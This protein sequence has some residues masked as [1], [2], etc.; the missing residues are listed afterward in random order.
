ME[1]RE[2]Q[3]QAGEEGGDSGEGEAFFF[4]N[5]LSRTLTSV[6]PS[7]GGGKKARGYF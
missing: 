6:S 3:P 7:L 2:G 4:L 5:F 1:E